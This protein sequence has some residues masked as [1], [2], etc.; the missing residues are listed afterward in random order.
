MQRESGNVNDVLDEKEETLLIE[1]REN[2]EYTE[3]GATQP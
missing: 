2:I 3:V 1:V